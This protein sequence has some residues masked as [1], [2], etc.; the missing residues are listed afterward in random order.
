MSIAYKISEYN[1]NRKWRRFLKIFKPSPELKVLDVGFSEQEYSKTDNF[2]E[3]HYPYQDKITALGID[4][5]NEFNKRYPNIKTVTYTGETFPFHNKEFDV[6]WSNAVIEHVGD[7]MKQL[8]FLQEINRVSRHGYLTTPNKMFPIEV[9]TRLPLL[10]YLPKRWFDEIIRHTNRKWAADEYMHL[11]TE[12]KLRR[13][14]ST[15]GIDKYKIYKNRIAFFTL[16][17][18]VIF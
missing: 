16:D 12:R 17:F 18:V 5:A 15:A 3:K 14:L 11:L 2:L 9:H 6:C 1:R 13:L 8:K 4:R 7:E 10:H